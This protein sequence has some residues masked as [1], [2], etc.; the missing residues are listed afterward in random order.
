MDNEVTTAIRQMNTYEIF[1]S[2]YTLAYYKSGWFYHMMSE[3]VGKDNFLAALRGI[4]DRYKYQSV[5]TDMFKEALKDLITNP[6][7]DWDTFFYQWL[8]MPGHPI[9]KIGYKTEEYSTDSLKVFVSIDQQQINKIAPEFY[10]MPIRFKLTDGN[11]N[12]IF[13]SNQFINDKQH[14]LFDFIAPKGFNFV[15]IDPMSVLHKSIGGTYSLVESKDDIRD[16]KIFPNVLKNGE[17]ATLLYHLPAGSFHSVKLYD[18]N[19]N[20]I[21]TIFEGTISSSDNELRF[22]SEQ[23]STG[24]YFVKI[25]S[26]NFTD[27][28]AIY[29]VE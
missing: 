24:A 6:P 1:G 20:Y 7:I 8:D 27:T 25:L 23:L 22:L 18:L 16:S 14:Q 19:G 29:I 15:E 10:K 21:K 9:Y 17:Y 3:M 4:L 26:G 2:Q 11:D 12:I 5:S 13:I 28:K